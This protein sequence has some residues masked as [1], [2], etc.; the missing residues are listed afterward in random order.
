MFAIVLAHS[1]FRHNFSCTNNYKI[2]LMVSIVIYQY[3]NI[4]GLIERSISVLLNHLKIYF[5]Y[6][7]NNLKRLLACKNSSYSFIRVAVK[8][9]TLTI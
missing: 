6:K 2:E 5:L 8:F 3:L 4:N 9:S 7:A 1:I